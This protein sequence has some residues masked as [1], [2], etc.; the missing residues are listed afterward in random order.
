MT[1][2]SLS[3]FLNLTTFL[4][5]SALGISLTLLK[6]SSMILELYCLE[7]K[8]FL[9]SSSSSGALSTETSTCVL[10][11]YLSVGGSILKSSVHC[12]SFIS[13]E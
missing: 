9:S 8:S 2:G 1:S 10:H 7:S 4:R 13:S 11:V 12:S 5:A 3:D 6:A